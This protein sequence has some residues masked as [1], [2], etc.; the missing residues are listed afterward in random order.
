VMFKVIIMYGNQ[1]SVNIPC[2]TFNDVLKLLEGIWPVNLQ[3]ITINKV[4]ANV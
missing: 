1:V 4:K 2:E 3:S